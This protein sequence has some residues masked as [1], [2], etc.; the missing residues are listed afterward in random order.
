MQQILLL[1]AVTQGPAEEPTWVIP[2]LV[3]AVA[4]AV[5]AA[6]ATARRR[7]GPGT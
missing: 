5:G 2:L 3:L 4:A 1:L 6:V 7:D